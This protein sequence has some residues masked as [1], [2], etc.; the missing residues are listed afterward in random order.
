[1]QT[2]VL[3][4]ENQRMKKIQSNDKAEVIMKD[5]LPAKVNGYDIAAALFCGQV[6]LSCDNMVSAGYRYKIRV[7][8]DQENI[9]TKEIV[10]TKSGKWYFVSK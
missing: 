9:K 1:M 7:A 10:Q 3:K 6:L 5:G 8:M 4:R 2:Y